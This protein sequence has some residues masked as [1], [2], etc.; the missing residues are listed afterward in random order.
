MDQPRSRSAA[1][2]RAV[3]AAFFD[4]IAVKRE[5]ISSRSK[6]FS[7]EAETGSRRENA[8]N[9]ESRA[10]FD[11]IETEKALAPLHLGDLVG[12][13]AAGGHDFH[14]SALLLADQRSRQR[15]F[16]RIR[17]PPSFTLLPYTDLR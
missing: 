3:R 17:P 8:S 6:A 4:A 5:S 13:G 1:K 9:Q 10:A 16:V 11:S 15:F 2:S 12:L 7:S 14:G